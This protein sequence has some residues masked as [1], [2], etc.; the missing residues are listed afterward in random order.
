MGIPREDNGYVKFWGVN[1]IH[2]GLCEDGEYHGPSLTT[3]PLLTLTA[4]QKNGFK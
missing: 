4:T 3:R 2:Y 1:K